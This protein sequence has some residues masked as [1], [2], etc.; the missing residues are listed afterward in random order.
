M[1][2]VQ[3]DVF[4]VGSGPASCTYARTL[5]DSTDQRLFMAEMGSQ[6]SSIL[7][8]NLKNAA[9]FQKNIAAFQ[10]VIVGHLHELEPGNTDLPGASATYAVGG[11]ASHWT[12]ATPRPHED[13]M[14]DTYDAKEWDRLFTAAELLLGT[15]FT[16]FDELVSQQ[17]ISRALTQHF[18]TTREI[19]GLPLAVK[20]SEKWPH[21]KWSGCDTILK[22]QF[23]SKR[24]TLKVRQTKFAHPTSG[25]SA[26][27]NLASKSKA[28][29][30]VRQLLHEDGKV[31]HAVCFD[32]VSGEEYLVAAKTFV[33]GG[34]AVLSPQ[35]LFASGL[36][37]ENVGRY[38]TDHPTAFCQVLL[39]D[40][41]LDWARNNPDLNDSLKEHRRKHPED[42]IPI[43]F[44]DPDPQLY[45]P[46]TRETPFHTQIHRE[47]FHYGAIPDRVDQRRIIHL[48]WYTKQDPRR[49]NRVT[50][51]PE[52]LDIWGLPAPSFTC[53]LSNA[54]KARNE[55][56]MADMK[57]FAN[58]LGD[59]LP[60]VEPHWRP[61]G[62]ALH[63]CGTTRIGHDPATS[64]LDPTS[65]VRG[66]TNLFVGG[67]CVIPTANSVNPTLTT[68]AYAVKGA[69]EMVR[70]QGWG[71]EG[72]QG[73]QISSIWHIFL[74]A[75]SASE[76]HNQILVHHLPSLPKTESPLRVLDRPLS[77]LKASRPLPEQLL[78]TPYSPRWAESARRGAALHST[79]SR[80]L[81][82]RYRNKPSRAFIW[83]SLKHPCRHGYYPTK[84]TSTTPSAP[85]PPSAKLAVFDLDG[86]LIK[87]NRF[88]PKDS[89]D[90][91][92]WHAFKV[93]NKLK[94]LHEEGFAIVILT[95]QAWK[96]KQFQEDFE[97]KIPQIAKALD[98]P[99]TLMA[100]TKKDEV[101]R[102]PNTARG[103]FSLYVE[104][105][106][107]N[108]AVD[109]DKSFFVGDA[110]G[111][112]DDHSDSDK[113][114][115]QNAGLT[116]F[117]PEE[118]FT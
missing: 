87:S 115:A 59:Y 9:Y 72:L 19:K 50:F 62:Q 84:L 20:T 76:D 7:G 2:V 33:V 91:K 40:K 105:Y 16:P 73:V 71:R 113:I 96:E 12:C 103:M 107:G 52:K 11:M 13:E 70:L 37:G 92:W 1:R 64:V 23:Y 46:Y 67:N 8:E 106:N 39:A 15:N 49:E 89:F 21:L 116:F 57:T 35:L 56:S 109:F 93:T 55:L 83:R 114:M 44:D 10:H 4:L 17:I 75:V 108:I 90:W 24:L 82:P 31:T 32:L 100:A 36:G 95:N 48:R 77:T 29:T 54:D 102:K 86:V 80:T 78:P 51:D 38:L 3:T 94:K 101:F 118:F 5:L 42:N 14:P 47:A 85:P 26:D 6:Q 79:A 58:V 53:S 98:L 61:Y 99:F 97:A 63:S 66:M 112:P 25:S 60:G 65:R 81:D 34:G 74:E 27:L 68:V 110:A 117:T 88:P 104:K 22:G 69:E 18:G 28:D 30:H 111:R 41:H 45:T 43:P